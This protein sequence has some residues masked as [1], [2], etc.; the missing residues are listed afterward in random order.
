M[1]VD[2]NAR[3]IENG[4]GVDGEVWGEASV[5]YPDWKGTAQLDER[6]TVPWEGLAQTVGLD[7]DQWQLVGFS[8]G[9]GEH[10][11]ELRVVATPRDVWEEGKLDDDAEIEVTE[12]LVHDVDPLAI[13]Q[14]M[15]H[16]FEL[17]MRIRVLDGRQIRVRAL[18]DLPSE[19][20]VDE[21][22]GPQED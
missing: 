18:S 11:Y 3:Y 4:E 15:T 14:R 9:G 20:F 7:S 22:F 10:G 1:L 16:M 5:T 21:I 2:R 19:K 12:F 6:L 8:I 13:L 17:K